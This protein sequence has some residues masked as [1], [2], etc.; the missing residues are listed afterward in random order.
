MTRGAVPAAAAPSRN[1]GSSWSILA[2]IFLPMAL[3]RSSASAGVKPPMR[4]EI[5]ISCSW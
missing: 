3:R 4:L 2:R 1:L 5:S